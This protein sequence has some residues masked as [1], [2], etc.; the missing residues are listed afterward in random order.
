V[1]AAFNSRWE[2]L[3]LNDAAVLALDLATA[4]EVPWFLRPQKVGFKV[5]ERLPRRCPR[6]Y[7]VEPSGKVFSVARDPVTGACVE[8]SAGEVS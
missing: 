1:C 7:R 8:S 3:T 2:K 4:T 5:V 6:F